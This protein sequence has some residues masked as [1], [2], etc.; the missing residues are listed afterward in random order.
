MRVERAMKTCYIVAA[1]ELAEER[2]RPE[3]L[4]SDRDREIYVAVAQ[5]LEDGRAAD[6]M[7]LSARLDEDNMARLSEIL[8][9]PGCENISAREAEDY[10]STLKSFHTRKTDEE[11][12]SLEA[13]EWKRYIASIAAKKKTGG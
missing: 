11:V 7:S 9:S 1:A 13:E 8:A 5:L 4:V 10:I 6:M 3:E 12:G 2:L